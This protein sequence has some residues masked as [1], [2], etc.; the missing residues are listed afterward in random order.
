MRYLHRDMPPG[1]GAGAAGGASAGSSGSSSSVGLVH[2]VLRAMFKGATLAGHWSGAVARSAADGAP[3]S[4]YSPW[5]LDQSACSL[6]DEKLNDYAGGEVMPWGIKEI[7]AADSKLLP[8]T[9]ISSGVTVC[10]I[11]SGIWAGHPDFKQ[12]RLTG[13]GLP[14]PSAGGGGAEACPFEWDEDIVAHGTHVAGT[15]GARRNGRGVVGVIPGG[16]DIYV[17]RIWNTSGDVSQGQGMYASD[18][19]RAYAACEARLDKLKA[20]NPGKP[21]RMVVSM[22]FGSAGPLTVERMWF[23]R[24]SSR[25]DD[26]MLFVARCGAGA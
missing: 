25:Q 18:L 8:E 26:A 16:A 15:I 9:T 1:P 3:P 4:A 17:V 11:D 13:C 24:A 12:D 23:E 14:G 21:Q 2:R 10:I 22:S 19:V 6:K 5:E 7:E 20:D